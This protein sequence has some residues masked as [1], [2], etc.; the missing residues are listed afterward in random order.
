[1]EI[2]AID[3]IAPATV[4]IA[5]ALPGANDPAQPRA[6]RSGH[7]A[8]WTVVV[9]IALVGLIATWLLPSS[10]T[11]IP[12]SEEENVA[13]GPGAV[14]VPT[15]THDALSETGRRQR[16]ELRHLAGDALDQLI[17][18]RSALKTMRV[19]AWEPVQYQFAEQEAARGE[20]AFRDADYN[21]AT[22]HYR[23][24]VRA[25]T[26]LLSAAQQL[27]SGAIAATLRAL[28]A[29]DAS[30]AQA[31]LTRA[32]QIGPTTNDL[33][34]LK[35]R[36][37]ALP[38]VLAAAARGDAALDAGDVA[39]ARRE[40][41]AAL[42]LDGQFE[43]ARNALAHLATQAA[44]QQYLSVMTQGYS[45]M[46]HHAFDA[47]RVAFEQANK[48]HP[49]RGGA[50]VAMVGL[51]GTRVVSDLA[52]LQAR[53][54]EALAQER[55]ADAAQIYAQAL[56][57]DPTLAFAKRGRAFA[58]ERV[59]LQQNMS[60]ALA[61]PER[62]SSDDVHKA[63]QNL[64]NR[65]AA[66][67]D[68]GAAMQGQLDA[69]DALLTRSA[70]TMAVTLR[71]DNATEVRLYRIGVLGKFNEKQV[72]LRPGRYVATGVRDGYK[73]ARL[74]FDVAPNMPPVLVRCT[75]SIQ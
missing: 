25:F 16:M 26:A 64:R 69:L 54:D 43:P 18:Q 71:S 40:Y 63:T 56:A 37:D 13:R 68:K 51:A 39:T 20:T 12:T 46:Q 11:S 28:A 59:Q 61:H 30:L 6:A 32:M 57:I 33:K 75:E 60:N 27:R 22:S 58:R 42:S 1:M 55:F 50:Q 49:E 2:E 44:Q 19:M 4:H 24:A 38:H 34:P 53:G 17:H 65:V 9:G 41:Q 62:Q 74:E 5:R 47:A 31:S 45:A 7:F 8:P 14:A 48:M 70:T 3:T 35:A 29:G 15:T 72:S 67:P 21:A 36:V 73:D 10:D 52:Q 66:L 23:N